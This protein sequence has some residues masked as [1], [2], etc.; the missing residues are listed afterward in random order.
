[1]SLAS[2]AEAVA[3]SIAAAVE[4]ICAASACPADPAALT[5]SASVPEAS[6]KRSVASALFVSPAG[7]IPASLVC[8]PSRFFVSSLMADS[9][10]F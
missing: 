7:S 5:F 6:A 9:A 2:E 10:A 1:M 4:I 3:L 8:R